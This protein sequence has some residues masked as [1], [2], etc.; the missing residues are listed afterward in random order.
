MSIQKSIRHSKHRYDDAPQYALFRRKFSSEKICPR[1][2]CPR[3]RDERLN[4]GFFSLGQC[5]RGRLTTLSKYDGWV[6]SRT[7]ARR[8]RAACGVL[9][10][11]ANYVHFSEISALSVRLSAVVTRSAPVNLFKGTHHTASPCVS[12]EFFLPPNS[13]SGSDQR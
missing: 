10:R 4:P 5:R 7:P 3:Q 8:R 6:L 9:R 2:V 1:R 12:M 13:A 11:F